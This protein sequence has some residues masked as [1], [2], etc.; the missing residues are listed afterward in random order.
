LWGPSAKPEGY[1]ELY[2]L[3]EEAVFI[4]YSSGP[5]RKDRNGGYNVPTGTVIQL[6]V[7]SAFLRTQA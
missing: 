6:S 3:R 2:N 4:E 1:A 5:C 7:S